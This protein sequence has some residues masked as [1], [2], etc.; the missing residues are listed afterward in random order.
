VETIARWI[1]HTTQKTHEIIRATCTDRHLRGP[2]LRVGRDICPFIEDKVVKLR[3]T[4]TQLFLEPDG[5]H[6]SEYYVNGISTSL[7]YEVQLA[8]LHSIRGWRKPRLCGLVT[9]LNMTISPR[10]SFCD[11]RTKII[12]GLY[13][14]GQINVPPGIE[15]AAAKDDPGANAR[16]KI[17][18]RAFVLVGEKL[19]SAS[20]LMICQ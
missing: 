5:R 8:F 15:E 19:I 6:T 10:H 9:P 4:I 12:S 17:K 13:F 1:T 11:S 18:R 16:F 14:A 3:I 7:P 2:K 20:S